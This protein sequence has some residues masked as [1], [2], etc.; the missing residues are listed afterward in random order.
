MH[1]SDVETLFDYNYWANARVRR[2]AAELSP[3]QYAAPA[4]V[5]A[6]AGLSHGSLRGALA[7]IL[8][9]E[10]VWRL[11]IQ[12]GVSLPAVPGESDFPALDGLRER[13]SAEERAMRRYLVGLADED[14]LRTVRYHD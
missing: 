4:G 11:R 13:W 9:P 3:E 6:H 10:I 5:P 2:A 1:K 7:H 12:E 14:L 8:G